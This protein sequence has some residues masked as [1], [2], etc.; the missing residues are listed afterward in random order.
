VQALVEIA[1]DHAGLDWRKYVVQDPALLRP[2]E[3]DHL[4]GDASKAAAQLG[5][6]PMVSF[7]ELVKM[8]VE[9]D[10]ARYRGHAEAAHSTESAAQRS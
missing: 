2:A 6:Q 8:M 10:L 1:F 9:A 3:V 4:I 5:W 7:A